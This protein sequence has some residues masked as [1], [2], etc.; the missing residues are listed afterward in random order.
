[1]NPG[2][3]SLLSNLREKMY[4]II[5]QNMTILEVLVISWMKIIF[6]AERKEPKF[7]NQISFISKI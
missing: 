7:A 4:E 1:M 3:R 2:I 6:L 5:M